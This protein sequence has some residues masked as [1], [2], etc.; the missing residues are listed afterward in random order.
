MSSVYF[1]LLYTLFFDFEKKVQVRVVE[2]EEEEEKLM[3][4]FHS[5]K[6]QSTFTIV[7]LT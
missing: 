2:V 4:R 5:M 6:V 3:N 7:T 1:T